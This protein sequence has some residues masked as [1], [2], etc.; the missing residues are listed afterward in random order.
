MTLWKY[1]TVFILKNI[2][3]AGEVAYQ[4]RVLHTIS[5]GLCSVTITQVGK[6]TLPINPALGEYHVFWP[7]KTPAQIWHVSISEQK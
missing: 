3:G 2:L 7:P 6:L 5:E 1:F 4:L